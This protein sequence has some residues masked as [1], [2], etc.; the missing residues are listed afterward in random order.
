MRKLRRDLLAC[1]NCIAGDDCP[2]LAQVNAVIDSALQ[3]A[4]DIWQPDQTQP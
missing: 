4:W 3:A 2:V 1:N